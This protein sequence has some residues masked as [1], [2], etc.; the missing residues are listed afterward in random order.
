MSDVYRLYLK[1]SNHTIIVKTN[2]TSQWSRD[3]TDRFRSCQKEHQFYAELAK[4][5]NIQIPVCYCNRYDKDGRFLLVLEDIDHQTKGNLGNS[6]ITLAASC[7]ADLHRTRIT[8]NIPTL[9]ENIKAAESDL[10]KPS[11]ENLFQNNVRD[12]LTH[13]AKNSEKF[14]V[15]FLGQPQVFSHMDFRL[16]NLAFTTNQ[17]TLLDW[18]DFSTA[19]RG[20]DLAY[21]AVTSM[22]ISQRRSIEKKFLDTYAAKSSGVRKNSLLQSYRLCLLP[23]VYLPV[24]MFQL[25]EKALAKIFANRLS[26]AIEDHYQPIREQ[27]SF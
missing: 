15:H 19:P 1:P 5:I 11:I 27:V 20:F 26:A 13:Y 21:F 3:L 23:T 6:E 12:L 18:G 7:L 9:T 10:K 24:L 2:S 4:L 17:L 14:L 16:D 8:E 22:S 25:G